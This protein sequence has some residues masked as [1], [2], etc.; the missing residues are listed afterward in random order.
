MPHAERLRR[1]PGT[2]WPQDLVRNRFRSPA[3]TAI[4]EDIAALDRGDGLTAFCYFRGLYGEYPRRFRGYWMDM[5]GDSLEL[6]PLLILD[7]IRRKRIV[8]ADQVIEAHARAF[9]GGRE[10]WQLGST[11]QHA[12][13]GLLAFAGSVVISCRTARGV[14]EFAVRR[15]DV[16]LVLHFFARLASSS[17]NLDR[18]AE[19]P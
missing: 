6:R 10:A 12:P 2:I 5:K 1:S 4:A 19:Q 16:E 15:P 8:I 7:R 17:S 11:G 18:G 13:G 3:R 9:D 14:L